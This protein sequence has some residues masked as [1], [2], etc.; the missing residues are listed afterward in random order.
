MR[1]KLFIILEKHDCSLLGQHEHSVT[2]A[3]CTVSRSTLLLSMTM[4][5]TYMKK[6]VRP[7]SSCV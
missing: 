5:S 2:A 4:L 1:N 7:R 6:S 3:I